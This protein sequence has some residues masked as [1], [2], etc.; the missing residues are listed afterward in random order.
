[1]TH[2]LIPEVHGATLR[3]ILEDTYNN[4]PTVPDANMLY[5]PAGTVFRSWVPEFGQRAAQAAYISGVKPSFNGAGAMYSIKQPLSHQVI[6]SPTLSNAASIA[7][8]PQHHTFFL[9]GGFQASATSNTDYSGILPTGISASAGSNDQILTYTYQP[10]HNAARSSVSWRYEEV[11][12][13]GAKTRVHTL[14]GARH[15]WTLECMGASEWYMDCQGV[16]LATEPT[17]DSSPSLSDTLVDEEPVAG[18]GANYAL[19]KIEATAATFGGGTETSPT[20]SAEVYG[21][22]INSNMQLQ[23]RKGISGAAGYSRVLWKPG[24]PT[25]EFFMDSVMYEDDFDLVAFVKGRKALRYTVVNPIPG[26]T[27]SFMLITFTG[28]VI[29]DLEPG[30]R[31][32]YRN[33]KIILQLGWP[34]DSSDGGGLVS[35]P[36][37]TVQHVSI[38]A[39]P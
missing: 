24:T 3:A 15:A 33:T 35:A 20:L 30:A 4:E 5:C 39:A 2:D 29:N 31:D 22:K 16:G 11:A 1:M 6:S 23:P 8:V 32:G 19:T 10:R 21:L 36:V 26:S 17:I 34:E 13:G 37:L 38:V 25:A 27:T 18:L 28:F 14:R 7:G 12:E 9:G